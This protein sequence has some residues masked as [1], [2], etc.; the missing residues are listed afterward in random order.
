M[1][2]EGADRP[3]YEGAV[4]AYPQT[5]PSP[6]PPAT[7][8]AKSYAPQ[9]VGAS[10]AVAYILGK[11]YLRLDAGDASSISDAIVALQAY[12]LPQITYWVRNSWKHDE[13]GWNRWLK[14]GAVIGALG[15]AAVMAWRFL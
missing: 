13:P 11:P 10:I 8:A 5:P 9:L 14:A 7:T 3:R 6:N 2:S 4:M 1:G 15:L 12:A